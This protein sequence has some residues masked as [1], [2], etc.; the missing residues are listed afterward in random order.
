MKIDM[1]P[2]W[3]GLGTLVLICA[4][5]S[6]LARSARCVRRRLRPAAQDGAAAEAIRDVR[7]AL[8]V[9]ARAGA[10][11]HE[12]HARHR[13]ALGRPLEH[14]RQQSH[15]SVHRRPRTARR[16][17]SR[18]RPDARVRESLQGTLAPADR[19]RRSALRPA[20]ALR[21]ARN[22]ALPARAV[23][24]RVHQP[25]ERVVPH[26][27]LR[28]VDSPRADRQA[29]QQPLR[30]ALLVRRHDRVLGRRQARA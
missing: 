14:G 15:G 12:A 8:Q 5:P 11:R 28:P 24:A 6:A 26:Q 1:R 20:R 18:R 7:R 30:H 9:P 16:Q 3:A 25:A 10:R 27:R 4:A 2:L 21:A 22:A 13:A 29:A 19:G 23:L 17:G